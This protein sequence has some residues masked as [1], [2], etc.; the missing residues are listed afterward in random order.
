MAQPRAERSTSAVQASYV[1]HRGGTET[2]GSTGATRTPIPLG[3]L[4]WYQADSPKTLFPPSGCIW[5][6]QGTR[7]PQH[8]HNHP[9]GGFL[10]EQIFKLVLFRHPHRIAYGREAPESKI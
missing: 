7:V 5:G 9:P 2:T 6:L 4:Q 3:R 10:T 8:P 1:R